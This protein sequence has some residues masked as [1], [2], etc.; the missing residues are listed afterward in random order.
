MCGRRE[1]GGRGG[2]GF[3]RRERRYWSVCE[4]RL[5]EEEDGGPMCVARCGEEEIYAGCAE[6]G[7]TCE[8]GEAMPAASLT[9]LNA[10]N[11]SGEK[12]AVCKSAVRL[13]SNWKV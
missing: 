10:G 6:R 9:G 8:A 4:R 1:R 13:V 3:G 7:K 11:G 5:E 2:K 12:E